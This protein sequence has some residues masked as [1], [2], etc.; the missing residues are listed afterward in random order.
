MNYKFDDNRPIYLQLVQFIR[1]DIVSGV[2]PPGSK[3]PSVREFSL[4]AKVSPNTIQK[5]LSE[6]EDEK[7]IVTD[8]TN[9]KYVS[10]DIKKNNKVKDKLINELTKE[11]VNSLLDLGLNKEDIIELIKKEG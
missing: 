5:A 6:L 3:L 4:K 2:F 8:R 9:G 1:N 11:Y 7:L 10:K